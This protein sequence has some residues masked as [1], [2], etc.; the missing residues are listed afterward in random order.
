MEYEYS[1]WQDNSKIFKLT[2]GK[3]II[4]ANFNYKLTFNSSGMEGKR[5]TIDELCMKG[6]KRIRLFIITKTIHAI[7]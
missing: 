7:I 6:K 2:P 3:S 1:S 5:R 4:K